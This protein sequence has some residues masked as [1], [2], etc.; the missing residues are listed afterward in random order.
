MKKTM[1]LSKNTENA[2]K[3]HP[4][5]LLRDAERLFD[6][7]DDCLGGRK[8]LVL[9]LAELLGRNAEI[10]LEGIGEVCGAVEARL[11][12]DLFDGQI[13]K[14]QQADRKFQTK[15]LNVGAELDTGLL[16]EIFAEIVG[17]QMDDA[18]YLVNGDR[19]TVV[20]ADI[21]HCFL[22]RRILLN[23]GLAGSLGFQIGLAKH[24]NAKLCDG[25]TDEF[26]SAEI[27]ILILFG[28]LMEYGN[29]ARYIAQLRDGT[30]TQ[31]AADGRGDDQVREANIVNHQGIAFGNVFVAVEIHGRKQHH[32]SRRH[33]IGF[34]VDDLGSMAA[35][36]I[37]QFIKI[38]PMEGVILGNAIYDNVK[39]HILIKAIGTGSGKSFNGNHSCTSIL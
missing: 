11:V 25:C 39:K 20:I 24:H 7:F 6:F 10:V 9:G 30:G 15:L 1:F 3:K 21:K 23:G 26:L 37:F 38:V 18:C 34:S 5:E 19:I 16:L 4:A 31:L 28:Q 35:F 13:G 36:N 27:G 33:L 29:D 2:D 17:G 8:D 14:L 22:D 32:K 12:G